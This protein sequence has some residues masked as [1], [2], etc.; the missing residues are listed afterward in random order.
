MLH[1]LQAPAALLFLFLNIHTAHAARVPI[2]DLLDSIRAKSNVPALAAA[3]VRSNAV[4]AAGAVG[5]RKAGSPQQV[6]INDKFHIGSC[7]KSMT[8]VLAAMLVE[9]GKLSWT[10]TLSDELPD[11]RPLMHGDYPN[12][13]IE[14]LLS[15]RAGVP[16]DL[17][18]T[19]LWGDA[20][21]HNDYPPTEQRILL[22]KALLQ[23]GPEIPPGTKYMYANGGY[24]LVGTIIERLEK[25]PWEELLT[26]R[27]FRP[28]QM[29][30][31]GFGMPGSAGKIDQPWG[32]SRRNGELKP[33][34]PGPTADNPAA[35]GPGGTVHCSV[36]D[37]ASYANFQLQ[38]AR[39]MGKLLKLETFKKLHTPM[40]GQ[41][42]ALGWMV[43][44]RKWA[45]GRTLNHNGTNTKN[46]AVMWIAPEIDFA[47][48]VMTNL[49][50]DEAAKACDD[51][52]SA[53]IQRFVK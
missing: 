16:G 6:T 25:R 52:A 35:I 8:A 41:D 24:T 23:R 10:N 7:T 3:V 36:L 19:E 43:Q 12:V 46:Y 32:H 44:N 40:E 51:A 39:G 31:A 20:W 13:T 27:L 1:R 33:V 47:A 48:V 21:K 34:P 11:W 9:E 30:N 50:G 42:Y 37:F 26:E 45:K 22:T 2:D 53:L 15:H 38:G 5:V 17:T 49:G 29:T 4:I 14:Q 18:K 28:L